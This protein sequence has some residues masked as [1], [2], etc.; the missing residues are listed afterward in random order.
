MAINK[1]IKLA[2]CLIFACLFSACGGKT[3]TFYFDSNINDVTISSGDNTSSCVAPCKLSLTVNGGHSQFYLSHP[4]YF[5]PTDIKADAYFTDGRRYQYK[6]AKFETEHI[7]LKNIPSPGSSND[8]GLLTLAPLLSTGYTTVYVPLALTAESSTYSSDSTQLGMINYDTNSYYIYVS[9]GKSYILGDY[10]FVSYALKNFETMRAELF[11]VEQ[12]FIEAFVELSDL[13]NLAELV[14]AS[15]DP[16]DFL[17]LITLTKLKQILE[18]EY[19]YDSRKDEH[20]AKVEAISEFL[21]YADF[22]IDSLFSWDNEEFIDNID[23]YLNYKMQAL[24]HNFSPATEISY[25]ELN[26]IG[27]DPAYPLNGSYKLMDS[28]TLTGVWRPIG[29]F[30]GK[31]DGNGQT[32][33]IEQLGGAATYNGLFASIEDRAVVEN[34]TIDIQMQRISYDETNNVGP[35]VGVLAGIISNATITN[36]HIIG[37]ELN[38]D[39]DSTNFSDPYTFVGGLAGRIHASKVS[40]S[41]VKLN[42]T[43]NVAGA[44]S[45]ESSNVVGGFTGWASNTS[46]EN[47]FFR[48]NITGI[49]ASTVAAFV[50]NGVNISL[51]NCYSAGDITSD[52]VATGFIGDLGSSTQMSRAIDYLP[53][54]GSKI[55]VAITG[56]VII[57]GTI[58]G[59]FTGDA[60]SVTSDILYNITISRSSASS[61]VK[62]DTE[63]IM[64]SVTTSS[65]TDENTFINEFGWDFTNI[66]KMGE[67]YPELR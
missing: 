33:R 12:P 43:T 9:D 40:R 8:I 3:Q 31:L 1:S 4:K 24:K 22:R 15:S 47:S 51:I 26:K 19:D 39:V 57:D 21:N 7:F 30:I 20:D 11:M 60:T 5:N 13:P 14:Q 55:A 46:Y 38:V 6:K 65:M 37:D 16:I 44:S 27:V 58:S 29:P 67:K 35:H 34:L 63:N 61:A 56:S 25:T 53:S 32:I 62:L 54:G 45:W 49:N 2:L 59:K 41:S 50:G 64:M 17:D 23:Q 10:E 42:I 28:G 66:W 52:L 36:V 48:G 18:S